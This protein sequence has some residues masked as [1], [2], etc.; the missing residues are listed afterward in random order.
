MVQVIIFIVTLSLTL[1]LNFWSGL[2]Y[3][4]IEPTFMGFVTTCIYIS[5]VIMMNKKWVRNFCVMG[6]ISSLLVALLISFETVLTENMLLD[7]IFSV[8]YAL[9]V[10]FIMPLFGLNF[11]TDLPLEWFSCICIGIYIAL[12]FRLK[13]RVV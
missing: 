4:D 13:G 1:C 3:P 5:V 2:K 8:Q 7:M 6:A 10:V 12:Y 11:I 9:Y